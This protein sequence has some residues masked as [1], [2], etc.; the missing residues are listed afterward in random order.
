MAD[1]YPLI[2][3]AV[4]ALSEKS[5]DLRRAVYER[6]RSALTEQ[7]RALDPPISEADIA[8]ERSSPDTALDRIPRYYRENPAPAR[9]SA[10]TK[11]PAAQPY[12]AELAQA[13]LPEA[14]P[15]VPPVPIPPPRPPPPPPQHRGPAAGPNGF[16]EGAP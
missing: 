11:Q 6:A 10:P 7:L 16:D 8:R 3:R 14:R 1:Y 13:F 4:E 12:P 9:P 2:A 15:P 5:P